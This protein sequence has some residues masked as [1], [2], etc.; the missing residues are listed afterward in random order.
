MEQGNYANNFNQNPQ[1]DS[2]SK[3]YNPGWQNHSNL[4]YRNP[5]GQAGLNNIR[6]TPGFQPIPTNPS[7][8]QNSNLKSLFENFC[9]SSSE[10]E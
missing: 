8:T 3:T 1:S 5:Q 10:T 4:S 2:F 9:S 6:Q 7:L